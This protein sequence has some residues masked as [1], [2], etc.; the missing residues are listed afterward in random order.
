MAAELSGIGW[1]GKNELIVNPAHS[2]AIRLAS[3]I[4]DMPLERTDPIPDG[5]G[6]CRACLDACTFLDNKDKLEN[7]REQCR[8]YIVSLGLEHEVCGKCIKACFRE[9][10]HRDAFRLMD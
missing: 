5:C 8:R 1:R 6:E 9:G 3:V 7:Y 4:T 10:V 2:C